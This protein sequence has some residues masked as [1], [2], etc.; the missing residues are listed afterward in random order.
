MTAVARH[1]LIE[2]DLLADVLD[3]YAHLAQ[4]RWVRWRAKNRIEAST[5]QRFDELLA[6]VVAFADPVIGEARGTRWNPAATSW[7]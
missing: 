7:S 2:P 4:D 6:T 1:R 5:P 3:G